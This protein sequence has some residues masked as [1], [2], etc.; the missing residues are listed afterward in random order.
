MRY[1]KE[2]ILY[3]YYYFK[4]C[5]ILCDVHLAATSECRT[6]PNRN[7]FCAGF[8]S[9]IKIALIVIVEWKWQHSARHDGRN[10]NGRL[11]PAEVELSMIG[12]E[13]EK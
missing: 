1:C 11:Y 8:L 13:K 5:I 3:H 2:S 6:I 7:V 4:N 10:E 9:L 12:K